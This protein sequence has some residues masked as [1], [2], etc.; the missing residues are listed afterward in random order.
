MKASS[1]LRLWDVAFIVV[2][3][4]L[5]V[6][7]GDSRERG[8]AA[9]ADADREPRATRFHGGPA[10]GGHLAQAINLPGRTAGRQVS[11]FGR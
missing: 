3:G 6:E 2:E 5:A 9:D 10:S 7:L 1:V 8:A 11:W 4:Q